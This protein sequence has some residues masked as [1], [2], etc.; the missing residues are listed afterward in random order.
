M[1]SQE[2]LTDCDQTGTDSDVDTQSHAAEVLL[3]AASQADSIT[4]SQAAEAGDRALDEILRQE[5]EAEENGKET[6][7]DDI[8]PTQMILSASEELV[9]EAVRDD[10]N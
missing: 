10:D 6:E 9:D 8:D 7:E 2:V 1:L 4:E 3:S 5:E